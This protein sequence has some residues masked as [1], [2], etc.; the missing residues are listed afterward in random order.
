[1]VSSRLQVLR[2]KLKGPMTSINKQ[3]F[4]HCSAYNIE[5]VWE[6]RRDPLTHISVRKSIQAT[7]KYE[8]KRPKDKEKGKKSKGAIIYFYW[9]P[10]R[11]PKK[12]KKLKNSFNRRQP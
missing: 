8:V 3:S 5:T 2:D 7:Y 11:A 1:M 4:L 9:I 10:L 12:D 6:I